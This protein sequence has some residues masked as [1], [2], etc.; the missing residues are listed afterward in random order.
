MNEEVE[1]VVGIENVF[2]DSKFDEVKEFDVDFFFVIE[3]NYVVR[4]VVFN[5]FVVELEKLVV[6]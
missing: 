1:F 3:L 4:R 2:I 6:V 5:D